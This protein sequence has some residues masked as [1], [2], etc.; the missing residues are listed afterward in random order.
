MN[1]V[2][3]PQQYLPHLA[4]ESRGNQAAPPKLPDFPDTDSIRTHPEKDA[5]KGKCTPGQVLFKSP[6]VSLNETE[7][8]TDFFFFLNSL[9][10]QYQLIM[11]ECCF[12]SPW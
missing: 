5:D 8:L 4:S 10:T 3:F 11:M 12:S 9:F 6:G 2:G 1:R 7:Y